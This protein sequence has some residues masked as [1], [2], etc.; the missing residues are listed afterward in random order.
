MSGDAVFGIVVMVFF[1]IACCCF[2]LMGV[3]MLIEAINDYRDKEE[4]RK[5]KRGKQR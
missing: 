2:V 5:K 3:T 1:T 4:E